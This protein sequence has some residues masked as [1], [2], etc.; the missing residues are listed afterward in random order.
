[1]S[2]PRTREDLSVDQTA[3]YD[4]IIDWSTGNAGTRGELLTVGGLAGTG[5]TSLLSVFAGQTK[6]LV[7]YVA[8]TGRAASN[9]SRKFAALGIASTAKTMLPQDGSEHRA[10]AVAYPAS[11]PESRLPFVGT[12]HR[13]LY[14]PIIDPKTEELRGWAK[15]E[16]LDRSYD[17]LVVD[18]ASMV[19]DDVLQD[20]Q[21]HGVPILAVGN[22]GQLPPVKSAG[23]MMRDPLL[24]LEKIHRQAL[25]SPIIRLAH[26]I[27]TG[28]R[29]SSFKD[30]NDDVRL[31]AKQ[32]VEATLEEAYERATAFNGGLGDLAVI[33]WTNRMRIK[34]NA[35]ARRVTGRKGPPRA[36]EQ[37]I[38]LK[39]SPPIF[40]GMRGILERDAQP[41]QKPWNLLLDA[42]FPDEGLPSTHLFTN[43]AQ[44]NRER[45][46]QSVEELQEVGI[47]VQTMSMAGMLFDFGY[48]LTAHKAQGSG[49]KEVIVYID[50][51]EEPSSDDYRRWAYTA[52]SR[53]VER[54][55][56]LR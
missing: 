17:L 37:I 18:E 54:L 34:L 10:S 39:N 21:A 24:R 33:S 6:L 46:F 7:A 29:L 47:D 14:R 36:G 20:L 16:V 27:R 3:V 30:W 1:M 26:H 28:E 56:V 45:P 11:S 48:C 5:K 41:G 38:C 50:R 13:L 49:F 42:Y 52:V 44:F 40:N 25:G 4:V 19:G 53:S 31:G 15:R 23:G 22:H 12:I 2:P 32:Q 9:L 51:P 43:A 8:Y 55:T 35:T